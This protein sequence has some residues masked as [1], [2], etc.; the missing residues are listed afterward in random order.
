M[1]FLVSWTASTDFLGVGYSNIVAL[2]P[3]CLKITYLRLDYI[4]YSSIEKQV[5]IKTLILNHGGL[6]TGQL[7]LH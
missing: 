1:S 6:G 4:Y 2:N 3:V 5:L 7:P